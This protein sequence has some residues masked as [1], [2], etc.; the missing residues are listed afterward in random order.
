M[1]CVD[2]LVDLLLEFPDQPGFG[3]TKVCITSAVMASTTIAEQSV[4][5][6][7]SASERS[8]YEML[9]TA[10]SDT[11]ISSKRYRPS[12]PSLLVRNT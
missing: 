9:N 12:H 2:R 3:R 7:T 5:A 11:Q 1:I 8:S 10:R 4:R 6:L